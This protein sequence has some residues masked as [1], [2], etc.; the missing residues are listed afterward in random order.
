VQ[1]G[2]ANKARTI[3][4]PRSH[5][6]ARAEDLRAER[7]PWRARIAP[8]PSGTAQVEVPRRW[9]AEVRARP[10]VRSRHSTAGGEDDSASFGD[11]LRELTPL[12]EQVEVELIYIA[13]HLAIADP[14]GAAEILAAPPGTATKSRV[15]EQIGRISAA[16]RSACGQLEAEALRRPLSGAR[17]PP[18]GCP[19]TSRRLCRPSGGAASGRAR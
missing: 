8:D 7:D 4:N 18:F 17:S 19:I 11:L 14:S 10:R 9:C 5:R 15:A 16:A 1:R 6:R 12:E 13:L 3:R 2:V